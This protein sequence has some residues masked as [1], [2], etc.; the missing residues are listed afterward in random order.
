MY[1]KRYAFQSD[2]KMRSVLFGL[3][4]IFIVIVGIFYTM[5]EYMIPQVPLIITNP[6]NTISKSIAVNKTKLP[7]T[8]EDLF[9][10]SKT[11]AHTPGLPKGKTYIYYKCLHLRLFK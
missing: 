11:L 9:V 5:V 4:V 2:T 8:K 6:K 10:C 7:Q 3:A 1:I